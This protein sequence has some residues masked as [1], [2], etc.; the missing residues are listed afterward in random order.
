MST[1][2]MPLPV[3]ASPTDKGQRLQLYRSQIKNKPGNWIVVDELLVGD[4]QDVLNLLDGSGFEIYD[5]KPEP[6]DRG[7]RARWIV[8]AYRI[9]EVVSS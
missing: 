5:V 1:A 6:Q 8:L 3:E 9:A 7:H 4:L 2:V